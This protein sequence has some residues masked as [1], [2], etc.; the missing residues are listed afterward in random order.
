[1]TRSRV[2]P[3]LFIRTGHAVLYEKLSPEFDARLSPDLKFPEWRELDNQD[4]SG[5]YRNWKITNKDRL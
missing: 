4:I 2:V 1:M 3:T 5:C